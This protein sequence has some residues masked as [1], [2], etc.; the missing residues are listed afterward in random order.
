MMPVRKF[1]YDQVLGVIGILIFVDQDIIE[2]LLIFGQNVREITEQD[3]GLQQKIVEIHRVIFSQCIFISSVHIINYLCSEI[4]SAR[5][6]VIIGALTFVL[7][8]TYD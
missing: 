8:V 3:I 6:Y 2:F 4:L 5:V 7:T 1:F